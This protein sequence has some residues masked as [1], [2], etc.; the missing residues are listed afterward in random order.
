MPTVIP[1]AW[2]SAVP[3]PRQ[4]LIDKV[5]RLLGLSTADSDFVQVALDSL[6]DTINDMNMA[7]FEFNKMAEAGIVMTEGQP[8]VFLTSRFY[9]ESLAH[10]SANSGGVQPPLDFCPWTEFQR[11]YGDETVLGCPHIYSLFNFEQEGRLYL[12]PTPDA[13]TVS[14]YTLSVEYYRRIPLVSTLGASE[15]LS[16]P[17][18]VES[19]L[20]YG[21]QKRLAIH[22]LG[23]AHPDVGALATLEM[24]AL[25]RLKRVDKTHPD[26][27]KRFILSDFA[28]R[29]GKNRANPAVYIKLN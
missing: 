13:S 3:V 27:K 26:E 10:L 7:L 8:Y 22:V 5:C 20:L 12:S 17:R 14:T 4:R 19:A 9:R 11:W 28:K 21:A 29:P 25:E 18:E 15:S 1:S 16:V 6:D 23:A 24:Q 2:V